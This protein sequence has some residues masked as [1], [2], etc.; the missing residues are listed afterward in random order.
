NAEIPVKASRKL[1]VE[2]EKYRN[3]RKGKPGI[4]DETV[5]VHNFR[6]VEKMNNIRQYHLGYCLLL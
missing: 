2:I 5:K 1:R 3:T 4:T 6:F